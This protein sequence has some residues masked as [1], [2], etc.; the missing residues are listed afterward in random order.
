M[1]TDSVSCGTN[2][3]R[4]RVIVF[5]SSRPP[6]F[7]RALAVARA[8]YPDADIWALSSAAPSEATHADG[9]AHVITHEASRLGIMRVGPRV[10]RELRQSFDAV[11]I[12]LMY[13]DDRAASNLYR[14]AWWVNAGEL[15]VAADGE[16]PRVFARGHIA[17]LAWRSTLPGAPDGVVTLILLTRAWLRR[18]IRRRPSGG[19][20]RRPRVLHVIDNMGMGGAQVQLAELL[21][22][23]PPDR[24]DVEILALSASSTFSDHRLSR[25]IPLTWLDDRLRAPQR[26]AAVRDHCRAGRFDVV[27]TWLFG[28]NVVGVAGAALADTPRIVTSVRSL[29]PGHYPEQLRWWHRGADA[30]A[31]RIADVVTVN[32]TAL[33]DDHAR[34]AWISRRRIR[35]VHNGLDPRPLERETAGAGAW[36]REALSLAP[37]A[38]V[39]GTVGRL[40]VEKDQSTFIRA[41]AALRAEG[42]DVHAVVAGEGPLFDALARLGRDLGLD[43][44]RLQW[45]GARTDVRRIIAGLDVFVLTSRIEGFPNALLEAAML[46]VPCVS[47]DVGGVADVIGGTHDLFASGDALG[48]ARLI[49]RKLDRPRARAEAAV[50]RER[51]YRLFTAEQLMAR[52]A[53]VYGW[54]S[55]AA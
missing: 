46:G 37:H 20:T 52:W 12:P 23:T 38:V 26:I 29:S 9:V 5:R 2:T 7:R 24:C 51:C 40:A 31:S 17:G 4:R 54:G 41:V 42:R 16:E 33:V 14:L 22:R 53:E 28:S 45:L 36:L 6:Q 30:L 35:V 27:H 34:W 11:V 10:R 13:R 25:P 43:G 39:I 44:S 48:A 3:G 1:S 50:V 55:A 8:R 49:A 47:S 21:N 19:A 15:V 32:A 18:A